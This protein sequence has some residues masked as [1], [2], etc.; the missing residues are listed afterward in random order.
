[1]TQMY[2]VLI[3]DDLEPMLSNGR[4][5]RAEEAVILMERF[6]QAR[7]DPCASRGAVRTMVLMASV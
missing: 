1:M 2:R 6:H 7:E 3:L 4:R 5:G